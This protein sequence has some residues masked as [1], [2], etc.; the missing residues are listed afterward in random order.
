MKHPIALI[1]LSLCC[2]L[3]CVNCAAEKPPGGGP[4]DTD[5]P[6]LVSSSFESGSTRV[7][8]MMV[9]EFEFSEP[10]SPPSVSR[11]IRIFPL[12]RHDADMRVR[13]RK[14]QITPKTPWEDDLVYTVILGKTISDLRN[15]QMTAPV[16]LSFTRGNE[17]PHNT[18]RGFVSG[19]KSGT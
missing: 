12:G 14:I 3:L 15:N 7:D 17:M 5:P 1:L 13:G 8:S 2:C 9:M 16:Q 19:L 4:P 11:S 10:L 18:I 6:F